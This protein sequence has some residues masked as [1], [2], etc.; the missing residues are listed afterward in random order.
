MVVRNLCTFKVLRKLCAGQARMFGMFLTFALL[1]GLSPASAQTIT[2]TVRGT[3][4]DPSGAVLAGVSVTATNVA[5][6]VKTA[7]I[8]NHDGA[9]NIQFLPIGQYRITVAASGFETESV[10]PI[11]LE[12]DQIA[13][14]DTRLKLGSTSITVDVSSDVTPT[15][16]TQDSALESTISSNTLST[17]PLNG[18]NFQTATLYVPG[19]VNPSMANMAAGDGNERDTD[20]SGSPSFNGA[21][22]QTN[23]YILDGVE[24]NETINNLSAYNPAPDAIQEMRVVTGNANAE[25][26][27]VN[28]GEVLIVTKGGTNQYR[29]SL[30][31]LF[32]NNNMEANTWANGLTTP[33]TP[34]LS[35]T[36]NQF[37]ATFG[38]P[39]RIPHVFNGK[40]KLFFFVDYLGFRYHQGGTAQATVPTVNMRN[41]PVTNGVP[42]CDFSEV[43][44]PAWGN[45]QLYNNQVPGGKGF[46]TAVPY[47]VPN[48]TNGTNGINQIPLVSP[49]AKY[50]FG[51]QSALPLPNHAPMVRTGANLGD[52]DNYWGY[53]KSQTRNN[54]GDIRIDF[55]A[56]DRDA[57]MGRFTIGEALDLTSH[58]VLPTSF[59]SDN[60]YP[61]KSFVASW[62][63]TFSTS[64]VNEFRPGFTREVWGQG[65]PEDP[66]GLFGANG[67]SKL[68]IKFPNQPFSGFSLMGI[69]SYESSMGTTA[70]VTEFHENNFFYGDSLTW[71]HGHHTMKFGAQIVRYQQNYYYSG[72][73]GAL[74]SFGY[75]GNYTEDTLLNSPGYGFADF[76]MDE[77]SGANIGGVS[78][79]VG[80]RQFRNAYYAQDDWRL[81][82]NLTL[83]IGMRYGYD[84]PNY[85]VNNKQASV[86]LTGYL[87][88]TANISAANIEFAGKDG[89]S[90]ALYDATYTNFMPRVGFAWQVK[91]RLVV[92][93]GYGITDDFEGDGIN[94]R[95]TQNAPFQGSFVSA[96][97]PP[98]P[99]SNGLTPLLV[100]NGF[101]LAPGNLQV[102]YFNYNA[103]DP[104]IKPSMVQQ[105]NLAF[106]YLID[107]KTS[108]KVSYVGETGQHLTSPTEADQFTTSASGVLDD[109]DCS[110]TIA[111][112]AP[113]CNLVG[114][115]GNLQVTQSE[116]IS[117]YNALQA[118]IRHQ[119]GNG[120]EYTFNY[121]F[122]KALTDNGGFY[123]VANTSG[124]SSFF[125]DFR[126]QRGDWGPTGQDVKHAFNGYFTYELPF[127]RGKKYGANVNKVADEALGGWKVSGAV[128]MYSGFPLTMGSY[129]MYYVNSWGAHANQYR[130][131]KHTHRTINNWFG[132][133]PSATPC[134]ATDANGNTIDNG[135]CAYGEESFTGFG[136]AKNGSERAPGFRNVDL[137]AFKTFK[138]G[139]SQTLQL[140]GE[141]FNAFNIASY[142]APDSNLYAGYWN[143]FGLISGTNSTQR[144]MQ[145]SMHYQ[146]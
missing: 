101:A 119:I 82:P 139:H 128:V 38:G 44:S 51:N 20:A 67:N 103:Y 130:K 108:A 92:R 60:D 136:N 85:E 26:G 72:N 50:L 42:T 124:A 18:L 122:S 99:T 12:I 98:T 39:V 55:K 144:I 134:L 81:L 78:G 24:M 1:L 102:S 10:G 87:L 59:P 135:S 6:N 27:N 117:N 41:C 45:I 129:E 97:T 46:S 138:F 29:G 2:A 120:L 58:P 53:T 86:K 30:Y 80:Q 107:S 49:V 63:H 142:A 141:A 111:P 109:G 133:D 83:N 14:I 84:Q 94:W 52:T 13:K 132:T 77:S 8:T 64:L 126:N 137:S 3:V 90:R 125:Q 43:D 143:S 22:A 131:M 17:M 116:G 34:L 47:N 31:E 75:S 112:A 25:Y 74:G 118:T 95:M 54:Q 127:G 114:N 40:D 96:P 9:Y 121:T 93:G 32:Q 16:Q 11:N 91:P 68:G 66:S 113:A 5:T 106:E 140:R 70:I 56:T 115:W 105:F 28:G 19:A 62:V 69:G 4:T 21:R 57:V 79:D 110:G 104:H 145:V 36:Q 35:S 7:T 100:E 37:G 15:L 48:G 71:Q 76:V 123:G 73:G 88:P 89:N 146:F 65:I 33:V 23:S 61:F